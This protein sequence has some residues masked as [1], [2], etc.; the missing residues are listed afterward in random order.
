[1]EFEKVIKERYSVRKFN[2]KMV[3]QEL[4]NKILESGNLAPTAKNK[5]PQKIIVVQSKEGLAKIDKA[6]KCRYNAPI[7]LIVASNIDLAWS[8][9]NYSS[10]E[11]D[12]TIVATHM[13]LAATNYGVDNI[14]IELFDKD[15]IKQEFNLPDNIKPICLMPLG[16]HSDDYKTSPFHNVRKD[17]NEIVE[18]R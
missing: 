8:N 14:W 7:C 15:I 12:A 17:L 5:Q 4:I 13:M 18:F 16:Y 9:N 6:T 10:Y 3:N 2:D 11:M 1:M